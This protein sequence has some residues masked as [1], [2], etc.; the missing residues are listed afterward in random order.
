[1]DGQRLYTWCRPVRGWWSAEDLTIGQVDTGGQWT[2]EHVLRRSVELPVR[3]ERQK[4]PGARELLRRKADMPQR[5]LRCSS[6]PPGVAGK[7]PLVLAISHSDMNG[8][9]ARIVVHVRCRWV[10]DR[11]NSIPPL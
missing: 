8:R 1:M 7:G 2:I 6:R 11:A 4:T 3:S 5:L 9:P 10:H